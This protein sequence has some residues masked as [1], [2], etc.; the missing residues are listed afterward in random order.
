[1]NYSIQEGHTEVEFSGE[2][3]YL[4]LPITPDSVNTD[5]AGNEILPSVAKMLQTEIES[6]FED[7]T[8]IRLSYAVGQPVASYTVDGDEFTAVTQD[9]NDY[10]LV[11]GSASDHYNVEY[12]EFNQ[13]HND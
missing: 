11:L 10:P 8:L 6:K 7:R 3:V 4:Q 2:T 1:M 13:N 9:G 12:Y 5:A